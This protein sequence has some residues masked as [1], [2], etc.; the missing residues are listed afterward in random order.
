MTDAQIDW[1]MLAVVV[2][3]VL[4]VLAFIG[5]MAT[6]TIREA[7][8]KLGREL[9]GGEVLLGLLLAVALPLGF[10]IALVY[11]WMVMPEPAEAKEEGQ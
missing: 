3:V 5:W 6:A 9:T 1:F 8:R 10:A 4:L 2:G 11:V 7:E